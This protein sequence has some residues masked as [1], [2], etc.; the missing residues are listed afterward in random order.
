V[1]RPRAS[2][3]R[4]TPVKDPVGPHAAPPFA[5]RGRRVAPDAAAGRD[6]VESRLKSP[7]QQLPAGIRFAAVMT[8]SLLVDVSP[9]S[10]A[11]RRGNQMKP[12]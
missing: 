4:A 6:V 2:S 5:G 3:S 9:E 8:S 12:E 1:A 11:G 7:R 10:S